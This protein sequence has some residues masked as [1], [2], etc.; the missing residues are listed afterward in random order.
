VIIYHGHPSEPSLEKCRTLAP[1]YDHGAEFSA[2]SARRTYDEPYIIDNGAFAAFKNDEAWDRDAFEEMLAWAHDHQRD[3][4]FVVIPDVVGDADATFDRSEAWATRID[5]TTY[6]AVQDGMGFERATDFAR[7][8]GAAG[9]FVGGSKDWKRST[10]HLWVQHAH[11]SNLKC[12]IARPWD[13]K[14]ADELGA[15]SVD[16]TTIVAWGSWEKLRQL[17]CQQTLSG[18]LATTDGG[19]KE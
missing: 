11:D 15:D 19:A 3:P 7:D 13:L 10:A 8:I 1:S 9:L 18:A 2:K 5:F 12:H 14:A 16:T 17:E 4:D 6:L